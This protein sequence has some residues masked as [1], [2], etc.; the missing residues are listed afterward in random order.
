M[1]SAIELLLGDR[2]LRR[3]LGSAASARAR[4]DMDL[5]TLARR[6]V[7]AALA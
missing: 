5:A 1:R 4:L 3:E 6:M 7:H 2:A